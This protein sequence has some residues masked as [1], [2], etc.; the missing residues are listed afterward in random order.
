MHG[1]VTTL[2]DPHQE[3]VMQLWQELKTRFGVDHPGATSIPHY[4][5]HISPEY[6]MAAL[7]QILQ[8]TAV[9]TPPFTL[10]TTGI[11]IF[12]GENPVVYLPIA[13]T[14]QLQAVH[15]TLWARLSAFAHGEAPESS[16]Y[17]V[18]NWFPHISLGQSNITAD[19][20]G[21]IVTWLN[22]QPLHW[23]IE[24]NNL[25]FMRADGSRHVLL[26]RAELQ[27]H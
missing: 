8:E 9:A 22:S 14:T 17:D 2:A 13:R 12:P 4:S 19:N 1:V 15:S 26:Y 5:Y 18:F 24:V 25:T 21:P 10:R 20:L 27:D 11:G 23:E 16:Y 6:D 7:P 3:L